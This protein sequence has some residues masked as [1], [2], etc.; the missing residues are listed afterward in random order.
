[1]SWLLRLLVCAA[2]GFAVAAVIVVSI[3][4]AFALGPLPAFLLGLCAGYGCVT[5]AI[6]LG[7]EWIH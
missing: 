6:A 1:M 7:S 3:T 5:A 2:I 4:R